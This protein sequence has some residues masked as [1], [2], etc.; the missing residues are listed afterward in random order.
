MIVKNLL[1]FPQY[2]I[3]PKLSVEILI[4]GKFNNYFEGGN[5]TILKIFKLSGPDR[6]QYSQI[7]KIFLC[8]FLIY[9]PKL[10]PDLNT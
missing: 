6:L 2:R 4:I 3:Q 8:T 7:S 9:R 5:A 10:F 1:E